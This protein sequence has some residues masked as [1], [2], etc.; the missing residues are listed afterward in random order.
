MSPSWLSTEIHTGGQNS[1][2]NLKMLTQRNTY[3]KSGESVDGRRTLLEQHCCAPILLRA[4]LAEMKT[5]KHY[6]RK[7][8]SNAVCLIKKGE[9]NQP[10]WLQGADTIKG[11]AF[12]MRKLRINT[13][14]KCILIK[15]SCTV[16]FKSRNQK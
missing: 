6:F 9:S 11:V 7:I 1:C 8:I 3:R 10:L 2:R 16:P 5:T 12:V 15:T 14:D 4:T 13:I